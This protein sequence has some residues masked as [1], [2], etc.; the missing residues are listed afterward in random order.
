MKTTPTSKTSQLQ[1]DPKVVAKAQRRNRDLASYEPMPGERD[2]NYFPMP[3]QGGH[4]LGSSLSD[5]FGW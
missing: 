3:G 2:H 4:P 1:P 5:R